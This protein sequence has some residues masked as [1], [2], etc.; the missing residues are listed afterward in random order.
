MNVLEQLGESAGNGE[1]SMPS[2]SPAQH[3]LMEGAAHNPAFAKKVG[4]PQSV[5]KEFVAADK[6][7]G[8]PKA[9]KAPSGAMLK[10]QAAALRK[11][12]KQPDADADGM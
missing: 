4:V 11:A 8:A 3:R 7:K 5:G 1:D 12:P 2:K 10:A 6:A 9:K